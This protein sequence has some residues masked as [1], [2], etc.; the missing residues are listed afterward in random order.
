MNSSSL[1]SACLKQE[2]GAS[3]SLVDQYPAIASDVREAG[4]PDIEETIRSMLDRTRRIYMNDGKM[5]GVA[6]FPLP[7][8]LSELAA[9]EM[10][11]YVKQEGLDRFTTETWDC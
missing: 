3:V 8:P 11:G 7:S 5:S 10:T 2:P 9:N 4:V 6:D 1:S